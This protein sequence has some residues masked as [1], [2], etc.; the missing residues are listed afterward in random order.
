[1]MKT[2]SG[3]IAI[4]S[5]ED[6]LK[7]LSLSGKVG[8]MTFGGHRA[9]NQTLYRSPEWKRVRREVILRDNGFDLAHPDY[10]IGSVIYIHHI[11]PISIEDL[12]E[13]HP[14]VFDLDNLVSVSFG[15]HQEIHYGCCTNKWIYQERLPND[16]CPWK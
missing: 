9:L 13:G 15:T 16:T 1:M 3:L 12:I 7:Y 10:P 8:E 5:F 6:R 2:Y 4:P 14:T 11:N